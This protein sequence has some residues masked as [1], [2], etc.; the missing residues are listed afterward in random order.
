MCLMNSQPLQCPSHQIS[1]MKLSVT[2][3]AILSMSKMFF[4]SGSKGN[5]HIQSLPI[6]QWTTTQFPVCNIDL[7]WSLA[8]LTNRPFSSYIG[9]RWT[10]IQ[11]RSYPAVT[12]TQPTISTINLH[13]TVCWGMEFHGAHQRLWP[14][15]SCCSS[16]GWW[17]GETG[18]WLGRDW[19]GCILIQHRLPQ[20][21]VV[22]TVEHT[23]HVDQELWKLCMH[24]GSEDML[25]F[26][27]S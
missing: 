24:S 15:C 27:L 10:C 6:W 21:D 25:C 19:Q 8:Q 5:T 4:C 16:R 17:W 3:I 9:Q 14:H 23:M 20:V 7:T 22:P 13:V 18:M 2:S 11:Q 12:S 26:H 1:T